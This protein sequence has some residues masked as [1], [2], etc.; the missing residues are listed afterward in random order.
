MFD[1]YILAIDELKKSKSLKWT[2]VHNGIFLDYFAIGRIK[3]YLKPHPLVIDIEHRMAALPGS[4]DIPVTITYSFDMAKFLV[5]ELD[6]EDWPEESRIAGD[7]I[8]WNEFVR[9]A[10]EA[11][12]ALFHQA[13]AKPP[14][15]TC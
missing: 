9:L 12:G 15:N 8:T 1:S 4:G 11:T 2:V 13:L 10:E 7:I 6:L 14:H 5:A 3:S